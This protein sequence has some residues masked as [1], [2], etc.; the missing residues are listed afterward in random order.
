MDRALDD[1]RIYCYKLCKQNSPAEK[2]DLC[3]IF[4]F[5]INGYNNSENSTI[6]RSYAAQN[7][8]SWQL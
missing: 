5:N 6:H 7:I 8:T 2:Y 4:I 3:Y 1:Y